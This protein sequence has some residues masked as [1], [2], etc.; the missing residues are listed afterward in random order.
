M[1]RA[2]SILI[3]LMSIIMI[4]SFF[5]ACV[6]NGNNNNPDP[7]PSY[8]DK[9]SLGYIELLDPYK[10][11]D[12]TGNWIWTD[13]SAPDT[14]VAFRKT[15]NLES[16]IPKATAYIAADTKYFMWVNG[17]LTVYDGAVKRGPTKFDTYYDCV[18]LKNLKKGKNTLA[19]LVIY[20]GRSSD[21]SIDSGHGGLLF[22]A[23]IGDK[24][25]VSDESFK[26]MRLREY[27]N[28]SLLRG[29]Y[30]NYKQSSMLG[31]WNIYY[32]AR[33]SIGDFREAD[34]DD[35]SWAAATIVAKPGAEPFNDLY[36]NNA[37]LISFGDIID[38]E[39][40]QD[41]IGKTFT[42]DT[43]ITLNLPF[44]RQFSPYFEIEAEAGKK[45]IYYTDTYEVGVGT[46]EYN[47]K[48]TYITAD[49]Q[50]TYENYP[51]RSGSKLIV[52]VPSGIK[53]IKL[54][55]RPSGYSSEKTGSFSCS[56]G[57]LNILWQKALNTLKINMRDTFMDCP[58][59][60]RAPYLGDS[61][62]QID[63]VFYSLDS[64]S[65]G[66][67]KNAILAV[68]GWTE[69]NNLIPSR[70]PSVKPHEI[71]AQSLAFITAAYN[72]YLYTGDSDTLRIFY[73]VAV[74]YLKVWNLNSDGLIEYR[75]GSWPW[76]DWGSDIDAVVIQN[77]WYYYA[78]DCLERIAKDL[79][80]SAD[81][82]FFEE[83]KSSIKENFAK[84]FKRDNGY[85]SGQKFDDRAN[86][87][88]VVSGLA[89]E[90]DYE[91]ITQI[92][93]TI[94]QA[95]PFMEKYV[96]QA[97]CI[98]GRYDEAKARMLERYSEMIEDE[99]TTL[100]E[101]WEKDKGSVNHGWSGG[102]MVIMSKYFAGIRP[103][104]AAYA[105]YEIVPQD[106]FSNMEVI[107]DTPKG[108]ISLDI[109]GNTII[110]K[111]IDAEGLLKLPSSFGSVISVTGGDYD[112]I[113][114]IDGYYC[115]KFNQ[116]SIYTINLE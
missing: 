2:K 106:M 26:V 50:Q 103:I 108:R 58:D 115:Y 18:E 46:Q 37:P 3:M 59:R 42:E 47:F 16:T 24:T 55:Y 81:N 90:E 13:I 89:N 25:I 1:K 62:N 78:L 97:L 17:D 77:C 53:F 91:S 51:W 65:Y 27:K 10:K 102:P 67:I 109:E 110:L 100:W 14:Y 68:V 34:Y 63:M 101:L 66:L 60:E 80:I 43:V 39:N 41:Y 73:P 92:L 22:E 23:E 84:K 111:T 9:S 19:F 112:E 74:N 105:E 33:D 83:R 96:L 95:S 69:T 21:S 30:P 8:V 48:D 98:M 64:D 20:N 4:L 45:L 82:G 79:N 15:F 49:G 44:N 94:K 11:N 61:T 36:L 32:D 29:D 93:T 75:N 28:R 86:A 114:I 38:Y 12:W 57:K 76:T 70:V 85:K 35:S 5:G 88:A 7:E 116:E 52:E 113:G 6:R 56:D 104:K 71:P 99:C 107:V 40:S 54:G 72:Y 31:E 87:L